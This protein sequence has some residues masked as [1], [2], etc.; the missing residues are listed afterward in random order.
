M[1]ILSVKFNNINLD[2][3]FDEDDPET[4][5][6]IKILAQHSKFRKRKA[7]TKKMSEELVPIAW[8]S[9]RQCN[10]CISE[11]MK[12]TKQNK[13]TKKKKKKQN[14]FVLSNDFTVYSLRLLEQVD[15]ENYT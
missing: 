2:K 5:I 10:F 8:H 15:T 12:Q 13:Q 3:N 4:I 6:L 7:V 14:Q 1:G 9:K 11:K